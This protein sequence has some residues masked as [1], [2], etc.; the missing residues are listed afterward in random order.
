[1]IVGV[2]RERFP[3]EK[4]VALVPGNV[5]NLVKAGHVV[6]VEAGAGLA[7]GYR[8]DAYVDKGA[9][10]V[11]RSRVLGESDLLAVVRAGGADGSFD[12]ELPRLRA[13]QCIVGFLDPLSNPG[14]LTE[15][16]RA[17]LTL[18]AVELVPRITRAQSMD[19]LS[20][21]ANLSGYKAVLLAATT[22]PRLFPMMMTAAG[23]VS[24]ARVF[25]IGAGVAGLQA[26]ATAKRL[27]AVVRA[28]DVRPA[29]REQVESVGAKFVELAVE[30]TQAEDAGGYAKALGEDFYARQRALMA[31]VVAASDVVI[32][33]AAIP[34]TAS[35]ILVTEDMVRS[36]AVG[37]VIVDLAAERGGN[38]ELTKADEVVEAH[39]VTILG[40][41][42][43]PGTVPY[44]A[45]QLYS[46]NVTT[47][48]LHLTRDG[49][50]LHLDL[51]DEITGQI[52]IARDGQGVQ[53]R[54]RFSMDDTTEETNVPDALRNAE[55]A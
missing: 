43:L 47:L 22:L 18:I 28:Y 6:R 34:G 1:M 30:T 49:G 36:M 20:S 4:R 9:E 17:G 38:C 37:S 24:P 3:G 33:T 31:E 8:D 41:T 12:E 42:N 46:K 25:V 44:H 55:K 27:G 11:L 39:G 15:L 21:M 40:P 35:P 23:T 53:G 7:A 19:A 16:V 10:V 50:E 26:A 51:E 45:S 5:P 32:T 13:G 54:V 52:V 29:V 2:L 48:I 14:A